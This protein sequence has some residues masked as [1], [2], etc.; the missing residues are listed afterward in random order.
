MAT[1]SEQKEQAAK[2]AALEASRERM[3]P[4]YSIAA[5]VRP[6]LEAL[7][8]RLQDFVTSNSKPATSGIE[9]VALLTADPEGTADFYSNVLGMPVVEARQALMHPEATRVAVSVGSGAILAFFTYPPLE[10]EQKP[11]AV[12]EHAGYGGLMHL[13]F[14]IERE[15]F[16]EAE[17]RLKARGVEFQVTD[18]VAFVTDPINGLV[19][20]FMFVDQPG[21]A[22]TKSLLT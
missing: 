2:E 21:Y 1:Q 16:R 10:N 19:I 18:T 11:A 7:W 12:Q 8:Q 14:S 6:K 15:H 17:S 13:A 9:H 5:E 20:E 4:G 3:N 22:T